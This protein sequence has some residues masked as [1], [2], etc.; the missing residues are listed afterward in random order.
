MGVSHS[1]WPPG[2]T[3]MGWLSVN[4]RREVCWVAWGFF[5]D[6]LFLICLWELQHVC[7]SMPQTVERPL[8]EEGGDS[9]A[10]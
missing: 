7:L 6:L 8:G 3:A 5:V 9:T 10:H 2:Q 1:N 4:T